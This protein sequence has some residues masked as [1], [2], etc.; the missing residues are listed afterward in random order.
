MKEESEAEEEKEA[1]TPA[2]SKW[3]SRPFRMREITNQST[4]YEKFQ[5][6]LGAHRRNMAALCSDEMNESAEYKHSPRLDEVH[7]DH[8]NEA[9]SRNYGRLAKSSNT[10]CVR[11]PFLSMLDGTRLVSQNDE[12]DPSR[13]T[14]N[15]YNFVWPVCTYLCAKNQ[16]VA[17]MCNERQHPTRPHPLFSTLFYFFIKF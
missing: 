5:Q 16:L 15:K 7:E 9:N 6:R 4:E 13:Q 12:N 14:K 10:K 1:E 3:T 2:M 8:E 17:W 11:T